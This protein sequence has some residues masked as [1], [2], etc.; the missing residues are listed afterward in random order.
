VTLRRTDTIELNRT[1]QMGMD[2]T[3]SEPTS[4][5]SYCEQEQLGMD[6]TGSEPTSVASSCEQARNT[7]EVVTLATEELRREH[8]AAWR[9]SLDVAPDTE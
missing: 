4:V 5:A 3:G 2:S 7:K 1:V 9:S 6:S 8:S